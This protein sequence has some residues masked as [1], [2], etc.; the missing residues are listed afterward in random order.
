MLVVLHFLRQERTT[1]A[2]N[3]AV[4]ECGE[5]LR[6][7]ISDDFWLHDHSRF[8]DEE[9]VLYNLHG[10]AAGL[11]A[12]D[13]QRRMRDYGLSATAKTENG[14]VNDNAQQFWRETF[15]KM[16]GQSLPQA[17]FPT[18]GGRSF[19]GEAKKVQELNM[20]AHLQGRRLL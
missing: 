18:A 20:P 6:F 14:G 19:D 17:F 10:G 8:V 16:A 4:D 3:K 5:K 15:A 9:N 13:R 2:Y 1:D 11:N 7:H 12:E